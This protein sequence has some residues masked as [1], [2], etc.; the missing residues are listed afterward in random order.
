MIKPGLV[1]ITFRHLSTGAILDLT[2]Q[3]GLEAIEWGGDIHVPHGDTD[4]AI[5]VSEASRSRGIVCPTYGSYYRVGESSSPEKDFGQVLSSAIA[6]GASTIRVWAGIRSSLETDPDTRKHIVHESR[7]ICRMAAENGIN[8]SYEYHGN[9]LTDH[10]GSALELLDAVSMHNL[11]TY[12]QPDAAMPVTENREVLK[13]LRHKIS[14]IHVFYWVNGIRF[15]LF[16]GKEA[17]ISYFRVLGDQNRYA[18]LEF[19]RDNDPH[20]FLEDAKVLKDILH[21]SQNL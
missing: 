1:S 4:T 6:L 7:L 20:R 10:V 18:F 13:K 12:W 9:T 2:E 5:Q 3:A 8:I 19:V 15:P 17:W 11:Q 16:S 21:E 14:H